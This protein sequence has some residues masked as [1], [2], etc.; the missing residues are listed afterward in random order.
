MPGP[1]TN[2]S[3]GGMGLL[4]AILVWRCCA[5]CAGRSVA[6]P[7]NFGAACHRPGPNGVGCTTKTAGASQQ[8]VVDALQ[9]RVLF[10]R[11]CKANDTFQRT[12]LMELVKY[13][14]CDMYVH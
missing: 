3:N 10:C 8:R 2:D 13:D 9:N 1:I 5:V 11:L 4:S 14:G 6:N 7:S 12:L